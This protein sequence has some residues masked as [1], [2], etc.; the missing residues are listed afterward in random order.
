ML[1]GT[2]WFSMAVSGLFTTMLPTLRVVGPSAL[3]RQS[4]QLKRAS[5]SMRMSPP[6]A[7][8][9]SFARP[10]PREVEAWLAPVFPALS[11]PLARA[12][13]TLLSRSTT[14]ALG[15]AALPIAMLPPRPVPTLASI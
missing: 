4:G 15:S 12:S 11:S 8:R 2:A 3:M 13:S 14:P 7:A 1:E 10:G 6:R 9:V 5:E